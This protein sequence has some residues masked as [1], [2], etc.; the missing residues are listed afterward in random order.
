MARANERDGVDYFFVSK[1]RFMLLASKNFFVETTEYGGN[2]YGCGKNQVDDDKVV[3]VDPAGYHSFKALENSSVIAFYLEAK[4]ETRRKR[5]ASRGDKEEDI[6]K[7]IKCDKIDFTRR[8]VEGVD[9]IIKTD[10]K[11]LD[12]LAGEIYDKYVKTLLKRGYK[13][14]LAIAD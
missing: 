5:M 12:K 9:F 6:N 7:R 11:S 10:N 4:E 3:I 13:P 8:K 2:Y 1:D 14:N